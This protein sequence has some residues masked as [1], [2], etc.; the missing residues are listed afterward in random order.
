MEY[1][2]I[3]KIVNTFGI[4]GELKVVSESEFIDDRFATGN[5]LYLGDEKTAV[6]VKSFRIH[7]G[8]VLLMLADTR[9]IND[10]L[11]YVDQTV[12]ADVESIEQLDHGFYLFQ[13]KGLNVYHQDECI[14]YVVDAYKT[15]QTLIKV[16]LGDKEVLIPFV[17]A[18]IKDVNLD[19]NRIDIEVIEGLL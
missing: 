18:F 9:D 3:G 1:L 8:N 2:E 11:Q 16:N 7:K 6:K 19:E 14:G 15:V 13:L 4:K 10:V 12:Y 5:I 17:D